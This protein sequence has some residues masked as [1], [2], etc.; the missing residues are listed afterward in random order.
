MNCF[1]CLGVNELAVDSGGT[2]M[3]LKFHA[4]VGSVGGIFLGLAERGWGIVDQIDRR[5]S[6]RDE[7]VGG[8]FG[9]PLENG[10]P[11]RKKLVE[12]F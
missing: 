10:L 5:I 11:V 1:G 6:F 12:G 4:E 9:D 3:F 8:I 2:A 7:S